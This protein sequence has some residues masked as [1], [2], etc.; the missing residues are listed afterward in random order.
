MPD[1]TSRFLRPVDYLPRS[2]RGKSSFYDEVLRE[3]I[4]SGFRCAQV[5]DLGRSPLTVLAMLRSRLKHRN[6]RMLVCI[7]NKRVFLK[8]LDSNDLPSVAGGNSSH[9]SSDSRRENSRGI[10]IKPSFD[11]V[12]I[13]NTA[14]VKARCPRCRALNRKDA[15]VCQDC[16]HDLYV[17]EEEYHEALASMEELEKGLNGGK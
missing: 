15:R 16:R 3:F 17:S 9:P 11:V 7:R 4:Y 14:I 2:R 6:E 10:D 12:T 1:K 13:L 5:K 8:R